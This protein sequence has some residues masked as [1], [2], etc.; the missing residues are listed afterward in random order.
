[1]EELTVA[2]EAFRLV[3][4]RAVGDAELTAD[5]AKTGTSDEA[6]EEGFQQIGIS[7]PVGGGEGL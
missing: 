4:Q 6:V 3:L 2:A 7:E 5:L 1:M